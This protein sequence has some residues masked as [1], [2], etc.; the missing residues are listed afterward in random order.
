M[1]WIERDIFVFFLDLTDF[2]SSSSE[3]ATRSAMKLSP[4]VSHGTGLRFM[5][6]S[7]M[8]CFI[9]VHLTSAKSQ[10]LLYRG[11]RAAKKNASSVGGD[12]ERR[13]NA[14]EKR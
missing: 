2:K 8:F 11:P 4:I 7:V 9:L 6:V 1:W 10:S 12:F 13:L 3:S 5:V 14:M